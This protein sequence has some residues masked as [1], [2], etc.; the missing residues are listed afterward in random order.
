M[1][2]LN[3]KIYI[4]GEIN[5]DLF[6]RFSRKLALLE[7][8]SD[9][10]VEIEIISEGGDSYT[11]LAFFDRIYSSKCMITTK[12]Y[13]L[14][15]SA[16]TLIFAAGDNRLIGKNAWLMV[17]E[18]SISGLDDKKVSEIEKDA[19]H[20]RIIENQW[21]TI[22]EATTTTPFEIWEQ[23]NKEEAYLS[24]AQCIELGIADAFIN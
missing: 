20:S 1:S 2:K 4:S 9:D 19:K 10:R 14:V 22:L 15:A 21:C 6:I 11:A 23:L 12:A 17:H 18:D 5:N 13:G 3:R 7:K 16:A 8:E 24:A